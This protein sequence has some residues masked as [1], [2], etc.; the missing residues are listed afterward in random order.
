MMTSNDLGYRKDL[1][2]L[3][4]DHRGSFEA[5]LLGVRD[6]QVSDDQT[7]E[8]SSAK[9]IIYDA[10]LEAS[11]RGD[12]SLQESA[13]LVDQQYGAEILA[14]AHHQGITSC[15]CIE[16]SGQEVFDF[17]YGDAFL[18]RLQEARVTFGKVLVRYNPEGDPGVNQAQ[19]DRLKMAC[20]AVRGAGLKFMF[21]LLVPAT[22][23]QSEHAVGAYDTGLRPALMARA[24][25][26]LQA[27]GIE[28]DVW[29]VEGMDDLESARSVSAQ[30]RSGG[31]DG[32]G[33]I[34][35]GRGEDAAK[36][37]HWLTV[38]AQTPGFIGFA[39]GRTTFWG[40]VVECQQGS[41]SRE[42]AVTRIADNYTHFL[43]L[44]TGA[45]G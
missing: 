1:F 27:D 6:G 5:G 7:R 18:S 13:I 39:V 45:R 19:R 41:I 9:R 44:F 37:D 35:L 34:I 31:R 21:E 20:D 43:R 25:E 2:I 30:A 16:K 28:P 36:V 10:F 32:V 42:E 33:L 40:P 17:E 15:T 4:F 12:V 26:E 22:P 3:P 24:M 29:K 23:G 14:D 38:G 11:T 8:I